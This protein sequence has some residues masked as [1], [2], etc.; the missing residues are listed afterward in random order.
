MQTARGED[1]S[2]IPDAFVTKLDA[3][4]T[5]SYSTL[6]GGA[7]EDQ[8]RGIAVD[9]GGNAYVTGYTAAANFPLTNALQGTFGGAPFDAF[10]TK[11]N[12]TGTARIYSTFVGGGVNDQGRGIA[13]DSAGNAYVAGL[14]SSTNFPK[15][16]AAQPV[17]GGDHDALVTKIAAAPRS[18]Q[19]S[20]A[21]YPAIETSGSV[22][23]TVTRTGGTLGQSTVNYATSNGTAVAGTGKDYTAKTG[24]LTFASGETSKSFTVLVANDNVDEP[25]ETV[26]LTLSAPTGYAQLGTRKTATISITDNDPPP[27]ISIK[28]ASFVEGGTSS[29]AELYGA[30]PPAPNNMIFNVIL[31]ALSGQS[32]TVHYATVPGSAQAGQDYVSRNGTLTIPA[33]QRTATI[34]VPIISDPRDEPNETFTVH[35]SIP[36]NGT[37]T[38]PDGRGTI[39][40]NDSPPTM[41]VGDV[42]LTEGNSGTATASFKVSLSRASGKTISVRYATANGTATAPSDYTPVSGMLTFNPGETSKTISVLIK[43]DTVREPNETVKLNL[44][45][46]TNATF[47]GNDSSA[48]CT[49]LNND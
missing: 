15:V 2:Q 23:I 19:F 1:S 6:L 37:I 30:N 7:G 20:L 28:D 25:T 44:S 27:N 42:T 16:N 33:G 41:K 26:N 8:G 24:T 29:L 9:G 10:V 11:L 13:V 18:V 14:T 49:I 45:T 3:G 32:V 21:N 31:S 17:F 35:L 43:G 47:L 34:S 36:T 12:S 38:D 22:T 39:T 40:D 5:I 4:S 48:I 46:P